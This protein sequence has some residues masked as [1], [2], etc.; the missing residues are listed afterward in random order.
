MVATAT[1]RPPKTKRPADTRRAEQRRLI[2][3]LRAHRRGCVASRDA[4]LE[5]FGPAIWSATARVR[6]RE[7]A[8]Q[9]LIFHVLNALRT[10]R[11]RR[12][13]T[14]HAYVVAALRFRVIDL[15]RGRDALGNPVPNFR[16]TNK[17]PQPTF[18][19]IDGLTEHMAERHDC[20]EYTPEALGREDDAGDGDLRE[21]VLARLG[22]LPHAGPAVVA[23]YL[24]GLTM[25]EVGQ[26][27][28]VSESRVSQVITAARRV[29]RSAAEAEGFGRFLDPKG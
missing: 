9:D 25:R 19:S 28:G 11:E 12:G 23:H 14:L 16:K 18:V 20:R 27:L 7:D 15:M 22:G 5:H 21:W 1:R 10:Y 8:R 3:L 4:L 24:D 26:R 13:M 29:L 6:Y 17:R 2:G